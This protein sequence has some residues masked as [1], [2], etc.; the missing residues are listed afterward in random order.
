MPE[1]GADDAGGI[2][3]GDATTWGSTPLGGESEL[4]ST[5]IG[6]SAVIAVTVLM[7]G[8]TGDSSCNAG[9][10]LFQITEVTGTWSGSR[11]KVW[12]SVTHNQSS[13]CNLV[14]SHADQSCIRLA[15][16]ST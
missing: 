1:W 12:P 5:R 3:T 9:S 15:G 7:A 2:Q 14:V 10:N 8:K 6:I 4:C 13:R 11:V 16:T